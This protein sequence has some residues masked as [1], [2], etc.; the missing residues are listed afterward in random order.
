MDVPAGTAKDFEAG[1]AHGLRKGAGLALAS[2]VAG[3]G[4]AAGPAVTSA[5]GTALMGSAARAGQM[6][7]QVENAIG[8]EPVDISD[9]GDVA[10]KARDWWN[11][12]GTR[13]K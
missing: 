12:G 11:A 7:D 5:A 10:L 2:G 8:D 1:Y 6:F 13:V 9:V 4:I 3:A